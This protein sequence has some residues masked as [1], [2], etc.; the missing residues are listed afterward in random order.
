MPDDQGQ[1]P[2]RQG[3]AAQHERGPAGVAE[4]VGAGQR[5]RSR[6]PRRR[7]PPAAAATRRAWPDL[8]LRSCVASRYIPTVAPRYT[9]P[10]APPD[11]RSADVRAG[12]RARRDELAEAATDYVLEHGLIGLSLR[13]LAAALGTSDRMLLYHFG[14]RTTWWP[15]CCGSP[16]TARWPRSGRCRPRRRARR[17]A[18]ALGGDDLARL[19]AASGCTSRQPRS[20]CSAG[21]PTPASSARPTR[22]GWRPSPTTWSP[23]ACRADGRAGATAAARRRLQGFLLDLPFDRG[24]R[25]L[26]EQAVRDLADAVGCDRRVAERGSGQRE[27]VVRDRG[28]AARRAT[29]PGQAPLPLLGRRP[30]R[31]EPAAVHRAVAVAQHAEQPAA[32][33]PVG[34]LVGLAA[35]RAAR[36]T[37]GSR[38]PARRTGPPP[39]SRRSAGR[40]P[41][42]P[43]R[44]A[45]SSPTAQRGRGR[46]VVGQQ[47]GGE[48]ALGAG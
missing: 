42:R 15:R 44:R 41:C 26:S 7:S 19:D 47:G 18:R 21:S 34:A 46:P 8:S 3:V 45:P 24:R 14:A 11:E 1:Q 2:D 36:R 35:P 9:Q 29:Q 23:P 25:G 16:T 39:G 48:V 27:V 30:G 20:A 5:R 37:P 17:G 43:G 22:C 40:R 28:R 13:P 32:A 31:L 12:Q 6:R 10:V 33:L 38:P 4:A